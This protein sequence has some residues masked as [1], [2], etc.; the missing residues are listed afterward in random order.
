MTNKTTKYKLKFL[1][2]IKN[3]NFEKIP[4]YFKKYYMY[5]NDIFHKQFGG[6]GIKIT[7][8]SELV[9]LIDK[10]YIFLENILG[11]E[12]TSKIKKISE[13]QTQKII[14]NIDETVNYEFDFNNVVKKILD[15]IYHGDEPDLNSDMIKELDEKINIVIK[16]TTDE[17]KKKQETDTEPIIEQK[18]KIIP[19]IKNVLKLINSSNTKR[20]KYNDIPY[21]Q[22]IFIS[23][24]LVGRTLNYDVNKLKSELDIEISDKHLD[25]EFDTTN[26]KNTDKYLKKILKDNIVIY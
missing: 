5:S 13:T 12:I 14:D 23:Q 24:P 18:Q 8:K 1:Y 2:S 15:P 4:Y 21:Y 3:K 22:P 9:Y 25:D 7:S 6:S 17:L 11:N 19:D 26:K 20:N 16:N 10:I